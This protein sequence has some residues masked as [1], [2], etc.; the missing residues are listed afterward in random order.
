MDNEIK[1]I[2]RHWTSDEEV[3]QAFQ[4]AL[5]SLDIEEFKA[6]RELGKKR[7]T[8]H[9]A[10]YI[11]VIR[12]GKCYKLM[13]PSGLAKVGRTY[14]IVKRMLQYKETFGT[15]QNGGIE[16]VRIVEVPDIAVAE[17]QTLKLFSHAERLSNS[18]ERLRF[19]TADFIMARRLE[20]S[21]EE[22]RMIIGERVHRV[23]LRKYFDMCRRGTSEAQLKRGKFNYD[24][25][26]RAATFSLKWP[27]RAKHLP[28]LS[29]VCR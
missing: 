26:K 2:M 21:K 12:P 29:D 14:N 22:K 3:E 5:V 20:W 17:E 27:R 9:I 6:K 11:Y 7:R 19:T 10:G 8:G 15:I 16:V 23:R 25:F 28:T 24:R 1:L 13:R 4:E 18:R